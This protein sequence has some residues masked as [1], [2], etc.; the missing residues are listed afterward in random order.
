MDV[1]SSV[2]AQRRVRLAGLSTA[3]MAPRSFKAATAPADDPVALAVFEWSGR[4]ITNW[5]C[6]IGS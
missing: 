1:S 4:Y 2:G 3:L 5:F 6:K